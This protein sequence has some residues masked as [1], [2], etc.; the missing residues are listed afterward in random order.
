LQLVPQ[1]TALVALR[2]DF[3]RMI[4]AGM[5]IGEPPSFDAIVNRLR[6]LEQAINRRR[7]G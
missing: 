3:Q 1:G 5:F 2:D 6:T 4:G 7:D